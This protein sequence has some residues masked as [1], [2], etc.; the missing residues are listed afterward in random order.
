MAP[1]LG[2]SIP[3]KCLQSRNKTAWGPGGWRCCHMDLQRLCDNKKLSMECYS[4]FHVIQKSYIQNEFMFNTVQFQAVRRMCF[5]YSTQPNSGTHAME[6]WGCWMMS[7]LHESVED[8]TSDSWNNCYFNFWMRSFS[9]LLKRGRC[10]VCPIL[11]L[12]L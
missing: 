6:Y 1:L 4:P 5:P 7:S 2:M 3:S 10:N 11:T 12:F 9:R 8:K